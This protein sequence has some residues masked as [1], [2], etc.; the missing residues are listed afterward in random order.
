M[1]NNN[2]ELSQIASFLEV[3]EPSKNIY[4]KTPL[5]ENIGI[6]T[7]IP[8]AKVDVIGN[9]RV[10]GIL[11]AQSIVSSNTN[12]LQNLNVTGIITSVSSNITGVATEARLVVTGIATAQN[13]SVVGV[14][15]F[16]NHAY[17]GNSDTLYFGDTNSLQIFHN[18]TNGY[19]T[20]ASGDLYLISNSAVRIITPSGENSAFFNPNSSV[21]L[22]FDNAKKFETT[23][24]GAIVTGVLTATTFVGNVAYAA[25]TGFSTT[26]SYAT[27]AGL[28]TL[29]TSATYASTAGFATQTTY[30]TTSG[31]A[32]AVNGTVDVTLLRSA[33]ISTFTNGPVLIG[34][35]TSTG[36]ASQRLQVYGG[37]YF[38]G[39]SGVG[40]GIT[41]PTNTLD[42]IGV[43]RVGLAST[44]ITLGNDNGRNIDVG[45]GS[46]NLDCYVDFY[47]TPTYSDYSAR[48]VR[49]TGNNSNFEIINRGTGSLRLTSQDAGTID[50]LTNNTFRARLDSSGN[51]GIGTTTNAARLHVL[52]GPILVGS[53][54]SSGVASQTLQVY[55]GA[56]F[57]N[58]SNIGFGTTAPRAS[59]DFQGTAYFNSAVAV[60]TTTV[61]GAVSINGGVGFSGGYS[62]LSVSTGISTIPTTINSGFSLGTLQIFSGGLSATSAR[63][64]QIDF[65]GGASTDTYPGQLLFR[66]GIGTNGTSQPI[67]ARLDTAGVMYANT[68]TSTSDERKKENIETIEDASTILNELR[69]VRFNWKETG[70]PS[71]GVI[72]QEVEKVLPEAVES[73]ADG[74]KSV[75]YDMLI[76]VLIETVKEQQ[77]RIDALEAKLNGAE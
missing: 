15:T 13:L 49:L 35:A 5:G 30:S 48:L 51:L 71:V 69:G 68:F 67:T 23:A 18:G 52:N 31:V 58:S 77:R 36:T 72:A 76:G 34:A 66:T 11:T 7:T 26:S 10:S 4:I 40:I 75:S 50:F 64:G 59:V 61:L 33:G 42:V 47:G 53:A 46:T 62:T 24:G 16:Q 21:D 20:N 3:V 6:G 43:A 17:F 73:D 45:A 1:S 60:G 27:V 41:N 38:N 28:S 12:T 54:T 14:T 32:T 9:V 37:A 25:S 70:K 74:M 56:Y 39:S 65:V 29:A 8:I 57:S 2:R 44:A 19:V 55:G 22:Y 63:G